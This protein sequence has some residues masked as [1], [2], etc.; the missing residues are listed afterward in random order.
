LEGRKEGWTNG[1]SLFHK[2]MGVLSTPERLGR[3]VNTLDSYFGDPGFKSQPG[4][5]LFRLVVYLS[6]SRQMT[7]HDRFLPNPLKLIIYFSPLYLMLYDLR[8][9]KSFIK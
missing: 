8:C 2:Q 7:G 4:N 3:E 5:Q 9:R 6:A 1:I